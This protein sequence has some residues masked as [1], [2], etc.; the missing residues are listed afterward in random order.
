[1]YALALLHQLIVGKSRKMR[2]GPG[3]RTQLQQGYVYKV[4]RLALVLED[5]E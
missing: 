4:K 2:F 5:T 1:M 3:E